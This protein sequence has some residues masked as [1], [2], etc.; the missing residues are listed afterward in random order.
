MAL[1]AA[2]VVVA[3]LILLGPRLL[4]GWYLYEARRLDIPEEPEDTIITYPLA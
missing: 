3:G 4:L 2:S 1:L